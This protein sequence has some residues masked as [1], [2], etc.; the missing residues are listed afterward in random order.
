[1]VH[2]TASNFAKNVF[3]RPDNRGSEDVAHG[4]GGEPIGWYATRYNMAAGW[5]IYSLSDADKKWFNKANSPTKGVYRTWSIHG[6]TT[7]VKIDAEKGTVDYFDSKKYEN[8]EDQGIYWENHPTKFDRLFIDQ[9][10][11][12]LFK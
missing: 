8:S 12:E 11:E 5:T 4:K 10:K 6:N 1:M 3:I 2:L 9:G 7:L